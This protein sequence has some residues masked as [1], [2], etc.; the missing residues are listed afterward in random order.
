MAGHPRAL[1]GVYT[2]WGPVCP[3]N[4]WAYLGF[5]AISCAKRQFPTM[6]RLSGGAKVLCDAHSPCLATVSPLVCMD[7]M[8][9][10]CMDAPIKSD[11]DV[12]TAN[13]LVLTLSYRM[14]RMP[15]RSV[16]LVRWV[17]RS[18]ITECGM[19][20]CANFGK[21]GRQSGLQRRCP[22][23]WTTRLAGLVAG[24]RAISGTTTWLRPER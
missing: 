16:G 5:M 6:G 1:L 19:L 23:S 12:H 2:R 11:I 21:F 9:S 18:R 7:A 3:R 8:H 15:C 24:C 20:R 13:N 17:V 22:T 4:A 10:V 14:Q